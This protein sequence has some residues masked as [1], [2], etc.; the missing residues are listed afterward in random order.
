MML[1]ECLIGMSRRPTSDVLQR[2]MNV[3]HVL[4][5]K[6]AGWAAEPAD[7]DDS[8]LIEQEEGSI[9]DFNS[10]NP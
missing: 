6:V 4:E 7:D 2:P 5:P 10:P 1:M 8:P 3:R 9:K